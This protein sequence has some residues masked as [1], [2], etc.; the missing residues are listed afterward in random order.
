MDHSQAKEFVEEWIRQI[1][2]RVHDVLESEEIE[3]DREI[4]E[5]LSNRRYETVKVI[6]NC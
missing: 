1:E 4:V 6:Q 2:K 3:L 5:T